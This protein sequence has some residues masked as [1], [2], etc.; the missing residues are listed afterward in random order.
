MKKIFI[1]TGM[2]ISLIMP[3]LALA[4]FDFKWGHSP[5][6]Y[7]LKRKSSSLPQ[8]KEHL[9]VIELLKEQLEV[10]KKQE[11]KE[12]YI[13]YFLR[14]NRVVNGVLQKNDMRY[15]FQDP[16]LIYPVPKMRYNRNDQSDP[17]FLR[18]QWL[19]NSILTKEKR[20]DVWSNNQ[21]RTIINARLQY[22][23]IV[24][25]AIS[26]QAFQD[27]Q[28]RFTQIARFLNNIDKTK[29]LSEVSKLQVHIKTMLAMLH[30]E[31]VK[32]QMI[33]N[34]SNN[35]EALIDIQKRKL[36]G[37]IV[38]PGHKDMPRIRFN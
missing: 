4:S 16:Q 27:A 10:Q 24:A 2:A 33:R 9:E 37:N 28:K 36:Y 13:S 23:G 29:D 3:N 7:V 11:D 6:P 38:H 17:M 15:F 20:Y 32:L 22:S 8:T 25:K 19:I 34:L 35:E 30:N 1:I 21:M 12:S 26:L 31:S 14:G 18:L 5:N